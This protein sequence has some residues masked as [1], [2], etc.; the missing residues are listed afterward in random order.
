MKQGSTTT[1]VTFEELVETW[2]SQNTHKGFDEHSYLGFTLGLETGT[3]NI[4]FDGDHS[5]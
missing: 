2:V 5:E 1:F 4:F 3:V